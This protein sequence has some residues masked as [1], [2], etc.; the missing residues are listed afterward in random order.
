[1]ETSNAWN[2]PAYH[3]NLGLGW[4]LADLGLQRRLGL[5]TSRYRRSAADRRDRPALDWANL[6]LHDQIK[7]GWLMEDLPSYLLEAAKN[8]GIFTALFM[9]Y[10]W[11]L[12]RRDRVHLQRERDALLREVLTTMNTSNTSIQE[13]ISLMHTLAA[14]RD[15]G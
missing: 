8:G 10:Q 13:T 6:T 3:T 12:E 1:M 4:Y 15:N 11:W 2:Y 5:W 9:L 7:V 14:R